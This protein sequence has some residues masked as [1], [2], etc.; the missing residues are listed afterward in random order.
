[1]NVRRTLF[2]SWMLSWGLSNPMDQSKVCMG[3]WVSRNADMARLCVAPASEKEAGA[4]PQ[5]VNN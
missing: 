3:G 5:E 4:T 2:Q 1:M